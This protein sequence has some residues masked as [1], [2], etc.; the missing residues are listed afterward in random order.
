MSFAVLDLTIVRVQLDVGIVEA[1]SAESDREILGF[2]DRRRHVIPS[3]D[4]LDRIT[5]MRK[6]TFFFQTGIDVPWTCLTVK[7][8]G[9]KN[10]S[11]GNEILLFIGN[12]D[13]KE[14]ALDSPL[15]LA[16]A[17]VHELNLEQRRNKHVSYS[18]NERKRRRRKKWTI[19]GQG[20]RKSTDN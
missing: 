18:S 11:H 19:T 8:P 7:I 12:E 16:L 17:R 4:I 5:R 1:E 13:D 14:K 20:W 9:L 3:V 15:P 2:A 6:R 10:F